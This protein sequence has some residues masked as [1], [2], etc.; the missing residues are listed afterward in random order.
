MSRLEKPSLTITSN[1]EIEVAYICY[2]AINTL[3][4]YNEHKI[5]RQNF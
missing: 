1:F 4:M 3:C 5:E 2:N